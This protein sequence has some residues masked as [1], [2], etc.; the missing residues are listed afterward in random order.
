MIFKKCSLMKLF[1][2]KGAKHYIFIISTRRPKEL[3]VVKLKAKAQAIYYQLHIR[4]RVEF[5]H[6]WT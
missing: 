5:Q 6:N 2:V 1:I 4:L 3:E